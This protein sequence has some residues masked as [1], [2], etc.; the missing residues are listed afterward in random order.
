[1]FLLLCL[2]LAAMAD[3]TGRVDGSFIPRRAV[4]DDVLLVTVLSCF[5]GSFVLLACLAFRGVLRRGI[6]EVVGLFLH[7]AVVP[8][9]YFHLC[10]NDEVS[11][12]FHFG[13]IY[14][15]LV[16]S[17]ILVAYVYEDNVG[18]VTAKVN[19]IIFSGV[20]LVKGLAL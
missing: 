2:V 7:F 13:G 19:I 20:A 12:P 11:V 1:M 8:F 5:L 16:L 14:M 6:V 4:G 17:F 15:F 9:A 3:K 10:E 18:L